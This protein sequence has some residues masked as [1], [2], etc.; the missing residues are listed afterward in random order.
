MGRRTAGGCGF[1]S[2]SPMPTPST[3]TIQ[4]GAGDRMRS[5][6]TSRSAFVRLVPWAVAI[7]AALGAYLWWC[8]SAEPDRCSGEAA[9][10]L[11]GA[12]VTLLAAAAVAA[13]ALVQAWRRA[14]EVETLARFAADSGRVRPLRV[15]RMEMPV[16]VVV[17]GGKNRLEC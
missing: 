1:G 5:W 15:G 6:L 11:V 8:A 13:R 9:S 16:I 2:M 14:R 4:P 10:A 17:G 3:R 7:V 12:V